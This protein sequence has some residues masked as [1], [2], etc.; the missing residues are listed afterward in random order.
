MSWITIINLSDK[1]QL[2][3]IN[4]KLNTIMASIQELSDKVDELQVK[5]DA[6]QVQVQAALA[7][8]QT[9]VD[10]LTA[11]LADGGTP[12]SRQAVVDKLNSA[13]ADLETTV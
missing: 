1:K 4:N 8:L 12:E 10:E 13:I 3:N 5:L 2:S 7:T 11:Q 9:T 6:E